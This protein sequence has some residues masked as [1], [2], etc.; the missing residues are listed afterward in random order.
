MN[1][2]NQECF[3]EYFASNCTA[4]LTHNIHCNVNLANKTLVIENTLASNLLNGKISL[5]N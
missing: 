4:Y 1:A 5:T 2:E 3:Y